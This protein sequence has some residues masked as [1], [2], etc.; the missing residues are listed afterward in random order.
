MIVQELLRKTPF[1]IIWCV[2]E[3]TY[4]RD[5]PEWQVRELADRS[6]SQDEWLEHLRE[7]YERMISE[8]REMP[9]A[10]IEGGGMLVAYPPFVWTGEDEAAEGELDV[11]LVF[12]GDSECYGLMGTP[13]EELISYEVY[14]KSLEVF[15]DAVVASSLLYELASYGF[16]A[17]RA[18]EAVDEL[19][20]RLEEAE[21]DFAEG[22]VVTLD[23]LYEEGVF[24]RPTEEEKRQYEQERQTDALRYEEY[25]TKLEAFLAEI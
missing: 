17:V 5:L 1:E 16:T 6:I 3:K 25:R 20:R 22:R 11:S 23:D 15:G 10:Q 13:W 4:Y 19:L 21:L 18:K 8:L 14:G 24:E 12:S 9:T 7:S 2:L